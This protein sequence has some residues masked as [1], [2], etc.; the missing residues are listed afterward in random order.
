MLTRQICSVIRRTCFLAQGVTLRADVF[1][2]QDLGREVFAFETALA[3]AKQANLPK[4]ILIAVQRTKSRKSGKIL[5]KL[6]VGY[7]E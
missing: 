6:N 1:H 7:P 4:T 3:M 5:L 2:P